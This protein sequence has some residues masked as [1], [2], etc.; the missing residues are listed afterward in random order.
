MKKL[1]DNKKIK[2]K[3]SND[4]KILIRSGYFN[5]INGYKN[6][7]VADT[8]PDGQHIYRRGTSIEQVYIV[9]L[10]DE[11]LR[12]FILKYTTKVEEEVRTLTG[13]KFD[14]CN[15]E[16]KIHWYETAAYDEEQPL[17]YR[18][19]IISK[20]YSEISR[21]RLEYIQ[22]YMDNHEI[23]PTWIM[24]KAV[25]FSTFIG[26]IQNSKKE[27][28]HA[29]CNLYG[30]TDSKELPNVK[31]LIGSLHHM[32][33]IRN[34]CAHNERIYCFKSSNNRSKNRILEKYFNQLPKP[35][36][37]ERDKEKNLFDLIV[38]FKYYLPRDEYKEFI[39][40]LQ[41]MLLNLKKHID[42]Q[43]FNYVRAQIGVKNIDDLEQ[44]VDFTKD[45]I[46]Y[47]KFDS[48]P[49]KT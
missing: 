47:N 37:R 6:P 48:Y 45:K 33:R 42:V 10:F 32:R 22:F 19:S 21:S 16:G 36:S 39:E 1:R 34:S 38:Y 40:I 46:E 35:Y 30:M 15:A 44:L 43:A 14:E 18:M 7:F 5:L 12:S 23:I 28:R 3:G 11:E 31:L 2:C 26:V 24:I 9:K 49:I 41:K 20:A 17:K 29:L 4:K 27:V 8:L 13:Y 25:N